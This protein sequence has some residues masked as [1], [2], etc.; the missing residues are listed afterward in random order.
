M[1]DYYDLGRYT[2]PV[3][4]SSDDARIWFNR[5]LN[6]CY[7]FHHE[8]AIRCFEKVIEPRVDAGGAVRDHPGDFGDG[9]DRSGGG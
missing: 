2:R 1:D 3:S 7:A 8:E 9:I 4:T 5:G 6:W